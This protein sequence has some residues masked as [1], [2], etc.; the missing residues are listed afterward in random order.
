MPTFKHCMKAVLLTISNYWMIDF[1]LL[2]AVILSPHVSQKTVMKDYQI[3]LIF[4][5]CALTQSRVSDGLKSS[6]QQLV[7]YWL[8]QG[9]PTNARKSTKA[10]L[11]M[12]LCL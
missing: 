3:Q 11:L 2:F 5:I 12:N 4:Y 1:I 6:G 10:T 7:K 9:K 8:E